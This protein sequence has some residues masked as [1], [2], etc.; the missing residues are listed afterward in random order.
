MKRLRIFL[1]SILLF[2]CFPLWAQIDLPDMPLSE[3]LQEKMLRLDGKWEL[4]LEKTPEQVFQLADKNIPSDYMTVVPGVW[5]AEVE[6]YGGES[7]N[8]FGCYRLV[9]TGLE[10]GTK[11][12]LLT[13]E[14][15]GT[16]CALYINRVLTAQTGDPFLMQ[17]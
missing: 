4:Y 5:N 7:P 2:S 13:Q 1:L 15:P 3:Y 10:P 6:D 16:S 9:L 14:A 11:Y 17:K 12:A 8:T